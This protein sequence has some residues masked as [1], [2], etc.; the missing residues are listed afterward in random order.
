[1]S[2]TANVIYD[3]LKSSVRFN[4]ERHRGA[5]GVEIETEAPKPYDYPMLKYWRCERD[6]SLRNNG[7]E[8]VFRGAVDLEDSDPAFREFESCNKEFKFFKESV[9]TSVHVHVN[10]LNET[11]LTMANFIT[12]Y[13]L[14]E[15]ILIRYSGPDRLSN[16]FCMPMHDAE[17]V[18]AHIVQMLQ[19]INRGMFNKMGLHP[20]SVKYGAI[21]C[22]PLTRWGTVELRS[23]RGETDTAKIK[24]WMGLIEKM[25]QFSKREGMTPPRILDVYRTTR[26]GIVKE[27]FGELATELYYTDNHALIVKNL[28]YAAQ[29]A[30]VSK[31]WNSFGVMKLKPV[32]KEQLKDVLNQIAQEKFE[33]NYDELEWFEKVDVDETYHHANRD[34]R[35]IENRE[36]V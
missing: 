33:K 7:V 9:S 16:L 36:D 17:G 15:N 31:D 34:V 5:Y 11:F 30:T 21:N 10:M 3:I 14:L 2:K 29:I 20:D 27:I 6:G 1:M 32:Y 19:Y 35:I 23:F 22:A 12:T 24:K 26:E 28:P 8:Y 4:G 25:K 18:V 13:A